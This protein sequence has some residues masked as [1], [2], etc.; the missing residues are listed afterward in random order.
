MKTQ[1][2]HEWALEL[3]E[4]GDIVD[5]DFSDTLPADWLNIENSDLGVVRN[6]GN[7]H[8]GLK[9]R[10]WAYVYEDNGVKKLP[11]YFSTALG[12]KTDIKVPERLHHELYRQTN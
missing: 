4:G 5:S 7:E 6:E 1:I 2:K 11:E 9:E 12:E 10:Y 8:E 3:L